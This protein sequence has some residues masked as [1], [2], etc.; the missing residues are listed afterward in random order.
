MHRDATIFEMTQLQI[1]LAFGEDGVV[2]AE[3]QGAFLHKATPAALGETPAPVEKKPVISV[4]SN[5]REIVINRM[6]V[7]VEDLIPALA[8]L[9]YLVKPA[10]GKIAIKPA[11]VS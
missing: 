8:A 5:T 9:G 2:S 4:D 6:H 3:E 7:T 11:K 1:R 10:Y